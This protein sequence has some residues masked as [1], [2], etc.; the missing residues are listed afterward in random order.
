MRAYDAQP[1]AELSKWDGSP[2]IVAADAAPAEWTSY[3]DGR[4]VMHYMRASGGRYYVQKVEAG[5][6]VS[7]LADEGDGAS[8]RLSTEATLAAGKKW[9]AD[10]LAAAPTLADC[11]A[12]FDSEV[13]AFSGP[14]APIPR[15]TDIKD[16]PPGVYIATLEAADVVPGDPVT[17]GGVKWGFASHCIQIVGRCQRIRPHRPKTYKPHALGIDTFKVLRTDTI[18]T[19]EEGEAVDRQDARVC[20]IEQ[21]LVQ[22][23]GKR[24]T[25]HRDRKVAK[26]RK[27]LR[28]LKRGIYC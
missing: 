4:R 5:Y 20:R 11:A 24:R 8:I 21:E 12:K 19:Y 27:I 7:F 16:L 6:A 17:V 14:A 15:G 23:A 10:H 28:I 25:P 26:L 9:V 22:Y 1:A 13:P 3:R 2:R 18:R